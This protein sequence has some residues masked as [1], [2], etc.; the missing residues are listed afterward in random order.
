[1]TLNSPPS[2]I[3]PL[4]LEE[5]FMDTT[6]SCCQKGAPGEVSRCM[7]SPGG[8]TTPV[9][10]D[11]VVVGQEGQFGGRVV[12][13]REDQFRVRVTSRSGGSVQGPCRPCLVCRQVS[14]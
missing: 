14:T 13:G 6:K 7:R 11:E 1:M 4:G 3:D 2:S 10:G 8:L 12:S 5:G 9:I